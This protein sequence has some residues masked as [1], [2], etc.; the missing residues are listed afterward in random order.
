M[1]ARSRLTLGLKAIYFYMTCCMSIWDGGVKIG[2]GVSYH[3]GSG[4]CGIQEKFG[5]FILMY[6]G[7]SFMVIFDKFM[8]VW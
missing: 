8:G 4:I 2:L 5:A 3:D 1:S 7:L 6:S